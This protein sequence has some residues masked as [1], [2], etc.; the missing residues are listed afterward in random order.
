MDAEWERLDAK[1]DFD[2]DDY[3]TLEDVSAFCI[4]AIHV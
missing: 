1:Q 2:I 3:N 4:I